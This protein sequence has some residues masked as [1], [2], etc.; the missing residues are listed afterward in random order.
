MHS[1]LNGKF[2]YNLFSSKE[3]CFF[4]RSRP[5][6]LCSV[7]CVW[8]FFSVA[9]LS[10][11]NFSE[12]FKKSIAYRIYR[13]FRLILS[14]WYSV[15]NFESEMINLLSRTY[16]RLNKTSWHNIYTLYLL[17][18]INRNVL[19]WCLFWKL[20]M[21]FLKDIIYEQVSTGTF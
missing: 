13:G 7:M 4:P 16:Y 18:S 21:Q 19:N 20:N 15:L 10:R 5:I 1:L 8:V 11:F 6:K 12:G 2:Y 3:V 14:T 17:I 9:G